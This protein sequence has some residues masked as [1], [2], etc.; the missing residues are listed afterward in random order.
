MPS[1]GRGFGS[2][3]CRDLV[4][5]IRVHLSADLPFIA[6]IPTLAAPLFFLQNTSALR[7]YHRFQF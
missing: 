1:R 7:V 6:V 3:L 2:R 4:L 5:R